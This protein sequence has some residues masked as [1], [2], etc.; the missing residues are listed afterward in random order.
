MFRV[1][2]QKR[3]QSEAKIHF[4]FTAGDLIIFEAK[5]I[6]SFATRL[7]LVSEGFVGKHLSTRFR[8]GTIDI[9]PFFRDSDFLRSEL[10]SILL[11]RRVPPPNRG[12][13]RL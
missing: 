11:H 5:F 7:L 6:H 12:T 3:V 4:S 8:K 10:M 13:I 1:A 9:V 2:G